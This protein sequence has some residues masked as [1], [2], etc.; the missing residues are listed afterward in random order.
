[1]PLISNLCL[2]KVDGASAMAIIKSTNRDNIKELSLDQVYFAALEIIDL[3]LPFRNIK[4]LRLKKLNEGAALTLIRACREHITELYLTDFIFTYND[5]QD[6]QIPNLDLLSLEKINGPAVV[7]LLR[8]FKET[9][10]KLELIGDMVHPYIFH[11]EIP[12]AL[13]YLSLSNMSGYSASVFIKTAKDTLTKLVLDN[14]NFTNVFFGRSFKLNSLKSLETDSV[15]K[16]KA[17]FFVRESKNLTK[18]RIDDTVYSSSEVVFK[19][20]SLLVEANSKSTQTPS[21]WK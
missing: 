17:L 5:I 3:S 7:Y 4:C 16:T 14:I 8:A 12:A 18:L 2:S 9:V 19:R 6:L 13:R 20:N 1:M 21:W 15:K 11:I 10:T